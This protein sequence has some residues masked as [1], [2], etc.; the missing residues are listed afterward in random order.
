MFTM[1]AF[2][3]TSELGTTNEYNEK[4]GVYEPVRAPQEIWGWEAT[5]DYTINAQLDIA[6]TYSYNE[7]KN[8]ADDVYLGQKQ[9]SAPT[10]STVINYRPNGQSKISLSY[11]HVGDRSRF[12]QVNG[13]WTGDHA[14]IK[15]Y[16]VVNLSAHYELNSQTEVYA[17]IEN[18]F[19]NK[20]MTARSQG[21]SYNGYN[22]MALGSS[23]KVGVNYTF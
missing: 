4:T 12:E 1:A 17:G 7:G 15:S 22:T 6:A 3:S 11:F 8:T 19:N 9:I 10:F 18:L 21:Y 16:D 13:K 5:V 14:P 20:Y 2:R 23:L